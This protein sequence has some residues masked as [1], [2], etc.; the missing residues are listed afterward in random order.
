MITT[1]KEVFFLE[2]LFEKYQISEKD[3]YDIRQ[4]YHLLSEDKQ[5]NLILNFSTL[6][7]K[8][9]VIKY[10]EHLE[11]GILIGDALTE[12][13]KAIQIAKNKAKN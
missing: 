2:R 8:L 4:I 13:E 12:I 9:E 1:K 11:Q 10:D 5:N 6:V 7:E 3:S